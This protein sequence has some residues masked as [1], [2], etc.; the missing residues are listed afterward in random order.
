MEPSSVSVS[1]ARIG[2]VFVLLAAS[3]A[4]FGCSRREESL[5][6]ASGSEN[7]GEVRRHA[8]KE[9]EEVRSFGYDRKEEVK[10]GARELDASFD[11][12]RDEIRQKARASG[13]EGRASWNEIMNDLDEKNRAFKHSL[14]RLGD[15]TREGW[16]E[17]REDVNAAARDT[18][19]ALDR[20]AR[21]VTG[22]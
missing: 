2:G 16:E 19:D 8:A 9:W 7:P 3:A 6:P 5:T 15:A 1:V 20:A 12:R 17:V 18:G 13:A 11:R 22:E 14:R 10:Q 4:E 21:D